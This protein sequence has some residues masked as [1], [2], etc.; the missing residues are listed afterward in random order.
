MEFLLQ[1]PLLLV[2]LVLVVMVG[3]AYI[4]VKPRKKKNTVAEKIKNNNDENKITV[5]EQ[6][7]ESEQSKNVT[8]N[9][10]NEESSKKKEKKKLKKLK[11]EITRVYE[12][13]K[14][15]TK[16]ENSENKEELSPI[17]EE[18]LKKMQFVKTSKNIS[19]LKPYTA[20]QQIEAENIEELTLAPH[21]CEECGEVHKPSSYFDRSRRLSKMIQESSFDDMFCSHISEK[22][23][24]MDD[25]SRHIRNCDEIEQKLFER[26]AKTMANS[27]VKVNITDDG[28]VKE[29]S[30]KDSMKSWLEERRRQ[31]LAKYVT[32]N[33]EEVVNLSV[34]YD[35]EDL[36]QGEFDLSARTVLIVDSILNR[37]GKKTTH[38]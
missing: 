35:F 29:L 1:N 23:M 37:K 14:L 2:S 31:E 13:K 33:N 26:A 5:S 6:S 21:E 12:K 17:E 16:E 24:N 4:I 20:E 8:E 38:N 30:D 36:T 11:P 32:S 9:N 18:F 15:K 28:K 27:E 7:E 22:Y 3:L 25:I 19:R 10:I 34:D